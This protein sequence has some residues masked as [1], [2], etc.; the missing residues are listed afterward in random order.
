MDE[1]QKKNI[2]HDV[3][4]GT[5]GGVGAALCLETAVLESKKLSMIARNTLIGGLIGTAFGFVVGLIYHGKSTSKTERLTQEKD[6]TD[7]NKDAVRTF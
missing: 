2:V 1:Q 5:L 4:S 7:A 3:I 6:G